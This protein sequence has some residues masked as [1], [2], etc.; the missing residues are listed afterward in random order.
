[1]KEKPLEL[2]R[3]F[4]PHLGGLNMISSERSSILATWTEYKFLKNMR[5]AFF[6]FS[7][8]NSQF[9]RLFLYFCSE[10]RILEEQIVQKPDWFKGSEFRS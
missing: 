7:F 8:L 3:C 4:V 2:S 5:I 10:T 9:L 6:F 1:M